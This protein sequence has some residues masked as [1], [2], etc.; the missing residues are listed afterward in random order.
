MICWISTVITV[1]SRSEKAAEYTHQ[2]ASSRGRR[3]EVI[4]LQPTQCWY[5]EVPRTMLRQGGAAGAFGAEHRAW[6]VV[7]RA[8]GNT[9]GGDGALAAK[10]IEAQTTQEPEKVLGGGDEREGYEGTGRTGRVR[11]SRGEGNYQG[12]SAIGREV[13]GTCRWNT[14]HYLF[15]PSSVLPSLVNAVP[16]PLSWLVW[17]RQC[18]TD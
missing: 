10:L 4:G 15:Y 11:R 5:G 3:G 16:P 18:L 8:S 1:G 2:K 17:K 13:D 9:D 12:G 6:P 14:S 7:V